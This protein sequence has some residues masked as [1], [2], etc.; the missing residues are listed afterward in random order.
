MTPT[1]VAKDG[2]VVLVTGS[3][4]GR[5][6]INTV[7]LVTLR[8]VGFGQSLRDAVDAPRFHHQWLPDRLRVEPGLADDPTSAATL[9]ALRRT[10]HEIAEKPAR[11]GDAH[12]IGLGPGGKGYLG[13]ADPRRGGKAA[14][15]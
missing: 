5:T 3:P 8:H 7:L 6:I 12:S 11:Q 10:G 14:G 4:G 13:V 1:I 15:Y 2:R 9:D